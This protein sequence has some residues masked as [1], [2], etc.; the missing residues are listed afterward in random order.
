MAL[1]VIPLYL[2]I[3][4][5]TYSKLELGAYVWLSKLARV[6]RERGYSFL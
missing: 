5:T 4:D 3:L 6:L 1:A 2:R